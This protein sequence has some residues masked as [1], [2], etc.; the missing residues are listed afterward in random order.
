MYN[1]PVIILNQSEYRRR[2]VDTSRLLRSAR[3]E[4]DEAVRVMIG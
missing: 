1:N 2:V 3:G 4:V